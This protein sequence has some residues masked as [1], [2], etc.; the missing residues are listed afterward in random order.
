VE[1][2]KYSVNVSNYILFVF[3]CS[4]FICHKS[5]AER[6]FRFLVVKLSPIVVAS[7]TVC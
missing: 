6:R 3:I 4:I 1:V 7:P 2:R 5:K